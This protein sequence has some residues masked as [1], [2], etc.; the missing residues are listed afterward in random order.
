MLFFIIIS[1]CLF[2]STISLTQLP[3]KGSCCH[4]KSRHFC[5]LFIEQGNSWLYLS[6]SRCNPFSI[7]VY[8]GYCFTTFVFTL[9]WYFV[10]VLFTFLTPAYIFNFIVL[11]CN[12]FSGTAFYCKLRYLFSIV[13]CRLSFWKYKCFFWKITSNKV[14]W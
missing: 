11:A 12:N 8:K 2:I 6:Y 3:K 10:L 1:C 9:K 4:A 7:F 13:F 5:L 14:L